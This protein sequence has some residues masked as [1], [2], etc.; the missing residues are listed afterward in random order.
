MLF[1]IDEINKQTD[2]LPDT[3]LGNVIYDSCVTISKA[4]ED[5]AVPN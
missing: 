4:V 1:A 3:D 2:L 5:K